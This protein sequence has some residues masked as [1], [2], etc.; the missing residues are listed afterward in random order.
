MLKKEKQDSRPKN[1]LKRGASYFSSTQPNGLRR[2]STMNKSKKRQPLGSGIV[3]EGESLMEEFQ[4]ELTF[5]QNLEH[6]QEKKIHDYKLSALAAQA[7]I[8]KKSE[9][10]KQSIRLYEI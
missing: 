1:Q 7:K 8:E 4:T 10:I 2:R 9:Q 6:E 3:S 5:L